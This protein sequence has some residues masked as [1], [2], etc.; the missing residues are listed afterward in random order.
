MQPDLNKEQQTQ[1]RKPTN[2]NQGRNPETIDENNAMETT[3]PPRKKT[4]RNN[5]GGEAN[6]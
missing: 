2:K 1:R 3:E 4:R 6:D 5:R